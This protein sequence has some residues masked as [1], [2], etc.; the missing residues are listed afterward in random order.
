MGQDLSA[1][2][3][4]PLGFDLPA[5]DDTFYAKPARSVAL[6]RLRSAGLGIASLLSLRPREIPPF[7]VCNP[8]SP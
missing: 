2:S 7:E 6:A 3:P 4:T 1:M 5:T 8:D